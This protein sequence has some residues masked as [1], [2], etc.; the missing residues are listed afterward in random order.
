M[1]K[2]LSNTV[3][4]VCVIGTGW[5]DALVDAEERLQAAKPKEK[6]RWAIVIGVI[7]QAIERGEPWPGGKSTQPEAR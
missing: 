1:Y 6:Q 5:Q 7:R 3:D 4:K 2:L